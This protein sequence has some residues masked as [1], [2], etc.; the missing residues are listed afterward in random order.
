[1]EA[2]TTAAAA[3]WQNDPPP[4]TEPEY[5]NN[6]GG[7]T[8]SGLVNNGNPRPVMTWLMNTLGRPVP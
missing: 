4:H 6:I 8:N 7:G 2:S 1:M 3:A 5:A